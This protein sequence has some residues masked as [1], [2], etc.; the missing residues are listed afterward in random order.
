A[1]DNC[2]DGPDRA[3]HGGVPFV[4]WYLRQIC[5]HEVQH[6]VR[7]VDYLDLHYY[8]QGS[9]VVDLADPPN[10]SET[11]EVS[12]RRLRSLEVL[13]DPEWDSESWISDLGNSAPWHYS[14]PALIRRVRAW[15]DASCP[16][17]GLA[18]TEYNW[19]ADNGASSALAQVEA[20]WIFAREGVDVAARWV[21]PLENSLVERAFRL[22]LDF[23]GE[24]GRVS[25][26]SVRALSADIDAL[27]A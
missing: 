25:G 14:R 4:D 15:I 2:L 6:G 23:D 8:P 12:A 7:L 11:A 17:T 27:G 16:G 3:A 10:G 26:D 1:A 19:G 9:G 13:Y 18:I 21:A 20:L 22:Y 24:G 5:S